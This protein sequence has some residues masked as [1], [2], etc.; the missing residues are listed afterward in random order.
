MSSYAP[1]DPPRSRHPRL[2]LAL[3]LVLLAF[4]GGGA[5]VAYLARTTSLFAGK[6]GTAATT[7]RGEALA[8]HYQPAPPVGV[9]GAPAIDP[10]TLV[11]REAALAAQLATN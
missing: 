5:A 4:V 7:E 9:T 3:V 2:W 10:A 6:A 1:N 11:T 8:S